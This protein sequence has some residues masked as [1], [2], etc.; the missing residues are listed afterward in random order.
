MADK[1]IFSIL[2]KKLYIYSAEK[3]GNH[4]R[5]SFLRSAADAN[6]FRCAIGAAGDIRKK[7]PP[8]SQIGEGGGM[9]FMVKITSFSTSSMFS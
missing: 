9:A 3:S 1:I 5:N 8:P 4:F 7:I 2:K 6:R